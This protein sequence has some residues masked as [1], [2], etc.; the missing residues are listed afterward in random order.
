MTHVSNFVAM[1][2][3][4]FSLTARLHFQEITVQQNK[5]HSSTTPREKRVQICGNETKLSVEP[6][7]K[8]P[9]SAEEGENLIILFPYKIT[10][11][12]SNSPLVLSSSTELPRQHLSL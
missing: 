8:S 6:I 9:Y 11:K 5:K 4:A 7:P 2:Y 1:T 12:K 10:N 3:D